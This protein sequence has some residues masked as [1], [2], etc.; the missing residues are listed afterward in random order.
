MVFSKPRYYGAL[1]AILAA[2]ISFALFILGL[3][4]P[5][6]FIEVFAGAFW[7]ILGFVVAAGVL[8]FLI[9]WGGW[10][11]S[12]VCGALVGSLGYVILLIQAIQSI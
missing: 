10:I 8:R 1:V 5:K 12:A 9:P 7:P 3:G 11:Y 2:F 6:H 4:G